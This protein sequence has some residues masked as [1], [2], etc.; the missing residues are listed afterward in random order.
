MLSTKTLE[1]AKHLGRFVKQANLSSMRT[2]SLP[3]LPRKL[4][5][6][7]HAE[8]MNLLLEAFNGEG[9]GGIGPYLV[10][11]VLDSFSFKSL[12][13]LNQ[14]FFRL[15]LEEETCLVFLDG[16]KGSPLAEGQDGSP[17]GLGFHGGEAEVFLA[18]E[19][20]GFGLGVVF[21]DLLVRLVA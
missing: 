15:F 2:P 17:S 1:G 7:L 5:V 19:K 13:A 20:Q 18:W 11:G 4:L 16:F 6:L 3:L 12:D 14:G 8:V 10:W 21:Q 9:L